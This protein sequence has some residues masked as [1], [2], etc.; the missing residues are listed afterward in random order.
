MHAR[1]MKG[2]GE[3]S[4]GRI[5]WLYYDQGMSQQ[6]I[7]DF[8]GVSRLTINRS[9]KEARESGIIEFRIHEKHLRCFEIEEQLRQATGLAA[10]TVIPPGPDV[11]GS[12]GSAAVPRFKEA[13]ATCKSIALGGGRTIS[14]MVRRLPKVKKIVTEHMVSMGEF[15]HSDTVYD[16]ET[17]AHL[18]TTKLNI[19]CHRID[20]LSLETPLEVVNAIRETPAVA[21]AIQM[22]R[23]SDIAFSSACDIETSSSIFYGPMSESLRGEL[24]AAGV[25]GEIEGTL[26]TLEGKPY[27][28]D[29]S[30]RECVPLPMKC[31]V[32]L[33]AGGVNKVNAIVGAIRG[34]FIDEL[35][36]DRQ[37]ATRILDFF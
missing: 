10:V 21:K 9:L 4:L 31:P 18:I 7:A 1:S 28:S 37:A 3:N 16:P 5:A 11:I 25:I 14:M 23:A 24:V 20:A 13:L 33:V 17:I 29:Y 2:N 27:E 26:Y 19:R 22:A 12:L 36:T 8:I 35:I 30:L 15:V 6:E 32:V 34:A